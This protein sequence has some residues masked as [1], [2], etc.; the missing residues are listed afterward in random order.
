VVLFTVKVNKTLAADDGWK[1]LLND[2]RFNFL[3]SNG[4]RSA[5]ITSL[6]TLTLVLADH[7]ASWALLSGN[8]R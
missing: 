4:H 1:G 8:N 5:V 3:I 2:K 6:G 7:R